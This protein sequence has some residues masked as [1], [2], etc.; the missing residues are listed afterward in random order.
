MK[1]PPLCGGCITV[2]LSKHF[3]HLWGMKRAIEDILGFRSKSLH[4]LW[5]TFRGEGQVLYLNASL[6]DRV[7]RKWQNLSQIQ[8]KFLVPKDGS[9]NQDD[10]Q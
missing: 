4:K 6:I 8:T 1:A 3:G 5:T 10:F 9:L 7:I 2:T